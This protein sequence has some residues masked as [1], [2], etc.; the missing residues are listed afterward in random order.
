MFYSLWKFLH[1]ALLHWK[2]VC[3]S[4]LEDVMKKHDDLDKNSEIFSISILYI[5]WPEVEEV[6]FVIH[7]KL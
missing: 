3:W 4:L 5:I 2:V 7:Y 1:P 6:D